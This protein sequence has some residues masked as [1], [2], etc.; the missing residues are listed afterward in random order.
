[1]SFSSY[2][3]FSTNRSGFKIKSIS[4][5]PILNQ[6]IKVEDKSNIILGFK[7]KFHSAEREKGPDNWKKKNNK[8]SNFNLNQPFYKM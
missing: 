7:K 1:M 8:T 4:Y 3:A 6:G 2:I 5:T